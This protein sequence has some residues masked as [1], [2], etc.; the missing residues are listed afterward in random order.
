MIINLNLEERS[1]LTLCLAAK[2]VLAKENFKV[3]ND[4]YWSDQV[5]YLTKLSNKL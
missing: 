5:E 2:I 4:S 3:T 1:W